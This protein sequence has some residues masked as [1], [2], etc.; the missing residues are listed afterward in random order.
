[1]VNLDVCM[2]IYS[3]F[4]SV[5]FLHYVCIHY[6]YIIYWIKCNNCNKVRI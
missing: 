6:L 2:P 3:Y 4:S 1:M 5:R